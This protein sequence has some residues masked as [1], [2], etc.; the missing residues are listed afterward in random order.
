MKDAPKLKD[1][2]LVVAVQSLTPEYLL[3]NTV[4]NTLKR[5]YGGNLYANSVYTIGSMPPAFRVAAEDGSFENELLFRPLPSG[6]EEVDLTENP[7]CRLIISNCEVMPMPEVKE[8][9]GCVVRE[10]EATTEYR[11]QFE[12]ENRRKALAK[13]A[14]AD[15][16]KGVVPM[17]LN[18]INLFD[19]LNQKT[20]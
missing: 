1:A 13:K 7:E 14:K 8:P 18:Q 3:W 16:K 4:E 17:Y 5:V 10:L 2:P 19:N 15:R 11:M 12:A 20:A 6:I 9:K